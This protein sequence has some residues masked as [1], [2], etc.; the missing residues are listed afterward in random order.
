MTQD[1]SSPRPSITA[2]SHGDTDARMPLY[3]TVMI[4]GAAVMVL[5]LLGARII[6]AFYGVSL[7]VWSSIIAVTLI[8]LA[9]GYYVGGT[10]ADRLP[11]IRL[12]HVILLA[13]A[14]TLAIPFAASAVLGA[15]D[16]WGMRMGAFASALVL[17]TL[18]LTS[19]AMVGPCVIK[20]ST[21]N[22]RHVGTAS[23]AVYAISTVG[24]V[25][26]TLLLGFY[27]L[28][29][30]GTRSV[31][32]AL[33]LGLVA[34]AAILAL[35]D[36][37]PGTRRFDGWPTLAAAALLGS[38]TLAGFAQARD[39]VPGFNLIHESESHY[40]WVRVVVDE[41]NG[42]RLLLSDASVISAVDESSGRSI[43]GYQ[44]ILRVLPLFRPHTRQALLI[45]LGGGHVARDLAAAGIETDTI[46]IDPEVADAARNHFGFRPTGAFVVGDARYEIKRLPNRYDYIMHDCFTGGSEPVHLL[47]REML[48]ELKALLKDD[49]ILALNYVGFASG[50]GSQ[51]V[52]AVRRTLQ[53]VFPH[54]RVFTTV[55]KDFTD[56]VFLVSRQPLE[57]DRT[58]HDGAQWLLDQEYAGSFG[59][60][61]I[62]TDDHN[63]LERWQTRKSEAYRT[64]FME[65]IDPRML[66]LLG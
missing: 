1:P 42:F 56:F 55:K 28:P 50:E 3:V 10:I 30:F 40:G 2:D 39:R 35:V 63:P 6:G 25:A 37:P 7:Y 13:A 27:L 64:L 49:G 12:P 44:A 26:G 60:G 62:L 65:R 17:F 45:G 41:A 57:L 52:A 36:R 24:S 32:F 54:L 15:T 61:I 34:L 47:T 5:E 16:S 4:T 53:S 8:A 21:W 22:L 38:L 18:P 20:R 48:L 11:G 33:S 58:N 29:Q 51:A 59:A 19:L 14:A 66:M 9:L 46:E 43:L 31:I 23:G